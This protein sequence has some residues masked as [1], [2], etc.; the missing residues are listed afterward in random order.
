MR[1]KTKLQ[2]LPKGQIGLALGRR[3]LVVPPCRIRPAG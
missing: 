1:S 2:E 3:S